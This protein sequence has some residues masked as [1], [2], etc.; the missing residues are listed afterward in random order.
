MSSNYAKFDDA[1]SREEILLLQRIN[2]LERRYELLMP[3][4]QEHNPAWCRDTFLRQLF[5]ELDMEHDEPELSKESSSNSISDKSYSAMPQYS[6]SI[7]SFLR[8]A[9]QMIRTTRKLERIS[10]REIAA[11]AY[12]LSVLTGRRDLLYGELLESVQRSSLFIMF[13]RVLNRLRIMQSISLDCGGMSLNDLPHKL[14]TWSMEGLFTRCQ[15]PDDVYLDVLMLNNS[16]DVLNWAKFSTDL[17]EILRYYKYFYTETYVNKGY[18]KMM[19]ILWDQQ[20]LLNIGEQ[21]DK[22]LQISKKT[23]AKIE[24]QSRIISTR[25]MAQF[26]DNLVKS[27]QRRSME[28]TVRLPIEWRYVRDYYATLVKMQAMKDNMPV[29]RLEEQ[30]QKLKDS[31]QEDTHATNA[32]QCAYSMTIEKYYSRLVHFTQKLS[33]DVEYWEDQIIRLKFQLARVHDDHREAQDKIDFMR[34]RVTE[35]QE[36]I[37]AE[38]QHAI[39]LAIT[40]ENLRQ[41]ALS[42]R[43]KRRAMLL[44]K[45]RD[46]TIFKA[47]NLKPAKVKGRKKKQSKN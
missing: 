33:D 44:K 1:Q 8:S 40:E 22:D 28:A 16:A 20:H 14:F 25:W 45:K 43:S 15:M 23:F 31:T 6:T 11:H 9:R 4:A 17:V 32:V 10:V 39:N 3:M 35:V 30:I 47:P 13:S 2:E 7:T 29:V 36:I 26:K 42:N 38:K 19:T 34:R 24:K 12:K 21:L 46:K 37:A 18:P 41:S 5:A 27:C